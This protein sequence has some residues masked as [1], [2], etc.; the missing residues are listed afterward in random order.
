MRRTAAVLAIGT[1]VA[2]AIG[3]GT[4]AASTPP[5]SSGTTEVEG[6][7]QE[8]AEAALLTLA[9]FP[10]GWTEEPEEDGNDLGAE[11]RRR[12]TECVGGEGEELLDLGGALAESGNFRGPD[13]EVVEESVAVVDEAVAE[14]FMARFGAAGVEECFADSMQQTMDE[15]VSDPPDPSATFPPDATIGT[16]TAERLEVAPAGDELVAYRIVIP[17]STQGITVDIVLD[18]VL[19]RSGRAVAAVSFQSV[20]SPFPS[21]DVE[22]YVDLAVERLP[23]KT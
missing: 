14:D 8:A 20:V 12:V 7:D 15:F 9:D 5:T 3:A 11:S 21:E 18:A 2:L 4:A 23:S 13:N 1:C 6:P 19:V 22:H 17:L 16:V 10:A